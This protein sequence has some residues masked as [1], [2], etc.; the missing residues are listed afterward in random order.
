MTTKG[1]K[2]QIQE[3]TAEA[4]EGSFAALRMTHEKKER[5]TRKAEER[6]S[7]S[8]TLRTSRAR[9]RMT[10]KEREDETAFMRQLALR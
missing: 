3:L 10:R 1:K 4:E 2:R 5:M 9:L 7:R 6:G 8:L